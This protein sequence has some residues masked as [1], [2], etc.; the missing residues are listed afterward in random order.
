MERIEEKREWENPV[1]F[2]HVEISRE[3]RLSKRNHEKK[4]PVKYK[5]NR[6]CGCLASKRKPRRGKLCV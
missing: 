2:Y 3:G 5:E 6:E 1:E 4:W